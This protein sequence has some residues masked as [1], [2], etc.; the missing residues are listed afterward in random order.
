MVTPAPQLLD[1]HVESR[2]RATRLAMEV[3][4]EHP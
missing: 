2:L 1:E 4:D 3:A